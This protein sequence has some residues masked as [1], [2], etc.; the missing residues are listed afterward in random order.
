MSI[1]PNLVRRR[2][3]VGLILLLVCHSAYSAET[4]APA[5]LNEQHKSLL[6]EYCLKCHNAEKPEGKFRVDTLPVEITDN[7]SAERWQKVLNALNSG[8][9]PPADETQLPNGARTDFLDDLTNVMT[10]VRRNLRDQHGVITMRRLNRREYG[11]SLR[12]LLGVQIDVSELPADTGNGGFDTS[13]SNLFMSSDQFEQYHALG[14]EAL[15]EAFERVAHASS[16]SKQ[17]FEA[18][19]V[20]DRVKSNLANRIELR[21]N[22]NIWTKAI[23]AAAER[24]ENHAVAAEIRKGLTNQPPWNFYHSWQKLK[25]VPSPTEFG[26]ADGE[27]ATHEG[28]SAWNLLPYQ[29]YFLSQLEVKNGAFLTIRDNGVNPLHYFG[30]GGWP[31]GDCI[32]RMKIAATK[33][34]TPARRFVEFG[35]QSTLLSTHEVSGTMDAPQVIEIPFNLTKSRGGSF[36][37]REKGTFDSNEQGHRVFAEGEKQNGIGPEFAL[38]VDW[39]EVE[40]KTIS[41]Q[42]IPPGIRALGIPPG[43]DAPAITNEDLRA[44]LDRF[45]TEACRGNSASSVFLDKLVNIYDERRKS[46]SGHG[47]A[48]KETLAVV[49]A[50]PRFL[51]LVEQSGEQDS[52]ELSGLELATR[53]SFFLWGAPPDKL[54]RDLATSGELLKPDVLQAET[55]RLIDDPR[56]AGFVIP[57]T[58]QWLGMDRLDFFRFNNVRYPAFDESTKMAARNEVYETVGYLLHHNESLR[59]L[60]KSDFVV[61]NS[62]L[63]IYYGIEGVKGDAYQKVAVPNELPRGGL[64]G[65]AAIL[66]MGSNGEQTSPV[67][68]GAWVLRK[69]INDPPPPAPANVPQISRLQDKLLTTR[70]RLRAHQE[71][72]QCASCHRK[73]DPVGLALENF[74]AVGQYRTEDTYEAVGLGKKTWTIDASGA[75]HHGP[76]FTNFFELRDVI[77]SKSDA[78]A[79]G[80]S[81][82]VLEYALGRPR[83]FRDEPLIAQMVNHSR[84]KDFAMREFIKVLVGSNEFRSK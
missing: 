69:L 80:F 53:L 59:N 1:Q 68:R 63:A 31:P 46:G 73:I 51:Y 9:M 25:N 13:G 23:D 44:A 74:N 70:E 19:D 14:L 8:S 34:A 84:Q 65:M 78:F 76:A 77:A 41:E 49:L 26:F 32:V 67:E 10:D 66:A 50:S 61:I 35:V 52:R 56:S 7:E 2:L 72:A 3:E 57:F 54:L 36:F 17:R 27:H 81:I 39:T 21:R 62:L 43:D 37:I 5:V 29:A 64:I 18:E 6:E 33:Q 16:S 45:T 82:A 24:P 20:V 71:E 58:N 11:N 30:I 55:N 12:E 79:R 75:F 42:Q 47:S 15:V 28:I 83:S 4:E 60:L 38:W 40:R 22:Y 48:F